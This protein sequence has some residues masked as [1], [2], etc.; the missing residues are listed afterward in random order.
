MEL[1]E[2][3]RPNF[4]RGTSQRGGMPSEIAKKIFSAGNDQGNMKRG[5]KWFP[6][7]I[8]Y[9]ENCRPESFSIRTWEGRLPASETASQ[10]GSLGSNILY[11]EVNA[12]SEKSNL[13]HKNVGQ[14]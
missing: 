14:N 4:F 13:N 11:R 12:D 6:V 10:Q 9:L 3:F 7:T 8:C 2:L 5:E 1:C